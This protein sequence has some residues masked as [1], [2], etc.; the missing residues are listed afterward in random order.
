ML[1]AQL[2]IWSKTRKRTIDVCG[3]EDR[4]DFPLGLSTVHKPPQLH[5]HAGDVTGA[6]LNHSLVLTG[7]RPLAPFIY[8][9]G[10]QMLVGQPAALGEGMFSC[11][12]FGK[13]HRKE[14]SEPGI[15]ALPSHPL[16]DMF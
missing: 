6:S 16:T 7:G 2:N 1:R 5:S 13:S 11:L 15:V 9:W 14:A 3:L 4:T 8:L 10:M 12:N